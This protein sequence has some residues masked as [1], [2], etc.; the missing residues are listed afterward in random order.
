M[1]SE[2]INL[3]RGVGNKLLKQQ[4]LISFVTKCAVDC[5]DNSIPDQS[6]IGWS[7]LHLSYRPGSHGKLVH[8]QKKQLRNCIIGGPKR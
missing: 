4:P 3:V 8:L 5:V 2:N 7:D 6:P 1:R